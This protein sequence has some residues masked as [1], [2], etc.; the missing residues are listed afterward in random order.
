MTLHREVEAERQRKLL[1]LLLADRADA[2]ALATHETDARALR[3]LR[4]YRANAD[5]SAARAL[6]T[7]F[8]TVAA[9]VGEEDFSHLARS[10]WRHEPPARG[11]LGAWGDGF[12]DWIGA[13]PALAEWPY[14]GDCA[15]LDWALH[16]CERAEDAVLDAPSI[17]RLGDTDPRRLNLLLAPG[18]AALQSPW[19]IALIL[20]AHR[21]NEDAAFDQV[22]AALEARRAECVLV[23]RQGWR[24]VVTP[25]DAATADWTNL[26]L[27]RTDLATALAQAGEG[28][29][30]AAWLTTALPSGWVKGIDV[31]PD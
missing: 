19:P 24:A 29:D 3:G 23:A 25:I 16:V 10:Y 14:L 1:T 21:R 20:D 9:M 27:A 17:A 11:D 8:P 15:R 4:A 7:A 18:I 22:R 31:V 6:G 28:F 2:S 12:A 26:L 30:F 5:A 13:H